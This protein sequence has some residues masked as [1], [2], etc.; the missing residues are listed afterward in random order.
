[1]KRLFEMASVELHKLDELR[2]KHSELRSK[3]EAESKRIEAEI[4]L[5]MSRLSTA[6]DIGTSSEAHK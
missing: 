6:I 2:I 5:C 1:M 4:S 3:F